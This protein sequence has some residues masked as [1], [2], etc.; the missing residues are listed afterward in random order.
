M[1]YTWEAILYKDIH[2]YSQ[3]LLFTVVVFC[4]LASNIELVNTELLGEI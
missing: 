1:I 2:I 4:K 3:P